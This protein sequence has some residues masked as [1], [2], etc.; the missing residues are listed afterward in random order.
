[1]RAIVAYATQEPSNTEKGQQ[2]QVDLENGRMR[3]AR[4]V[5]SPNY[6]ARPPG[7][8]A[9]L[10]VVHGISLPPGE[11]GGP[12]ID[13]LFMNSLPLDVH[14]YFAEIGELRVSSHL[15][16][17]RDGAL[18]QFVKFTDRA[19]HAGQSSYD[20]R[21]A[22]NDFSIGVELEGVDT[23][24]YE[25]AQYDT[26]AEVVAALCDAYPRLSTARVV[27]HSD[28]SPGRKTDPGPA[29]D[30]ERARRCIGAACRSSARR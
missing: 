10:I 16:V 20:G 15:L 14:P 7:V 26:L 12:W 24:D 1:M 25:A 8:A 23:L 6:D 22:C 13:K 17:A 18:T 4:Q 11:F 9:D 5:A 3:G 29:F 19:W 30:W 28:I 27:G 2:L 21:P